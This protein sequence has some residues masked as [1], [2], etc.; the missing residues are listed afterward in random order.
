MVKTVPNDRDDG[1]DDK[2]ETAA[3][4]LPW[5]CVPQRKM[6]VDDDAGGAGP[7]LPLRTNRSKP[8]VDRT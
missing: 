1:D 4:G 2:E 8:V 3:V 6:G 7:F 5:F